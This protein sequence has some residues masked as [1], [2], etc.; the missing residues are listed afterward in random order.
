MNTLSYI[1]H[2]T[3]ISLKKSGAMLFCALFIITTSLSLLGF[4]I[5]SDNFLKTIIKDVENNLEIVVFLEDGYNENT[6]EQRI[7]PSIKSM[8]D[9]A[10][11][12]YVSKEDAKNELKKDV[13]ELNEIFSVIED[14]PLPASLRI[15][16]KTPTAL[17]TVSEKIK[18]ENG[19]I[20]N[21]LTYGGESVNNF[22]SASEK[23]KQFT[24]IL[25]VL[26]IVTSVIVTAATIKLTI[27]TRKSDIEIMKLVGA[28][29]WYIKWPYI[30]EGVILGVVSSAFAMMLV[31]F[32]KN[33]ALLEMAK[34]IQF[35]NGF[36]NE[37]SLQEIGIKLMLVGILQG[38]IGALW[39]TSS[40]LAERE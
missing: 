11:V 1:L 14:N 39:S 3:W 9:V 34:S 27:Y 24:M 19:I 40:I 13:P 30:I 8:A 18:K 22:L 21:E 5:L 4:F 33:S 26:F 37:I 15:K 7:I 25:L 32:L 35:L 38:I 20:I 17:S 23:F 28:T 31:L 12:R 10:S 29:D 6:L 36:K 16:V 2:E